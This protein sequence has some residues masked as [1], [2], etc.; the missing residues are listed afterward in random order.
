MGRASQVRSGILPCQAILCFVGTDCVTAFQLRDSI[1]ASSWLLQL[2]RSRG[3]GGDEHMR[4]QV[5]E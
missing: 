1:I 4:M 5:T 2:S 3:S